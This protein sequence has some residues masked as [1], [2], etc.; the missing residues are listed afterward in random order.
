[1]TDAAPEGTTADPMPVVLIVASEEACRAQHRAVLAGAGYRVEEA[2]EPSQVPGRGG[3]QPDVIVLDAGPSLD[4]GRRWAR[5]LRAHPSLG[6]VPL[7]LVVAAGAADGMIDP[8]AGADEYLEKPL[9]RSDLLLRVRSMSQLRR[10]RLELARSADLR[11]EQARLWGVAL[12]LSRSLAG[13]D[14]REAVFQRI[15]EATAELACSRRVALL[16]PDKERRHLKLAAALGLDEADGTAYPVPVGSPIAGAVFSSGQRVVLNTSEDLAACGRVHEGGD[17]LQVPM[18]ATALSTAE[19]P[20]GVLL[21]S[22]RPEGR[23]FEPWELEFIDL[24]SNIAGSAIHELFTR[25]SRD[26]ARDSIVIALAT[27]AEYRD[28]D[29]GR[30]VD[31]VTQ[32]CLRLAEELRSSGATRGVIDQA[33]LHDLQRAVPLHDIG[34][35]AIPDAILLKPGPLTP[36]EQKIMQGHPR[37]GRDAIRSV[38]K[39]TPGVAFLRMAEEI[40]SCHHESYDGSGYPAGLAGEDIPLSAR[41]ASVAD[42]YDAITTRRVYSEPMSHKKA[43]RIVR[44]ESGR[45]F[46]PTIVEAFLR[47]EADLAALAA[48]MADDKALKDPIADGRTAA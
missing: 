34:K 9:R 47:C 15:V 35:V 13:T 38:I 31:R 23:P 7:I 8:E 29:T 37:I 14:I 26:E 24:L 48:E 17:L 12:D 40:V 22:H 45:Q 3:P 44:E 46:D 42:V 33:Y 18:V 39:Q 11:A 2:S 27:L 41:I 10:T 1:M 36:Q 21:I 19:H 43:V 32:L 6:D 30:H 20:V 5:R 16:L 25:Q 4:H 28:N